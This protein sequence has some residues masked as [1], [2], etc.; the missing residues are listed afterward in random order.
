[1]PQAI[2]QRYAR[3]LAAVIGPQGDYAAVMRQLESFSV[4]YQESTELRE[5]FDSPAVL[6]EQKARVL[7]AILRRLEV[8]SLTARFLRVLLGH[9]RL[10]LLEEIRAALRDI[11]NGIQGIVM[12]TVVSAS[13]LSAEQQAALRNRFTHL[14]RKAVEIEYQTDPQLVGGVRAQLQSTVYD[15]SVR[16]YLDRVREQMETS[17]P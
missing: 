16:G 11:V 8:S 9:Y 14:T 12:M 1:M 2:A 5:V 6:P 13:P 3:A 17:Q 4:A 7:D 15:G 10:N